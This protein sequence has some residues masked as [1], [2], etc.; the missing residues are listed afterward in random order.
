MNA[1]DLRGEVLTAPTAEMWERMKDASLGWVLRGEDESVLALQEKCA[2]LTGQ[3]AALFVPT[4][5]MGNLI[6]MM[7]MCT[8]GDQVIMESRCHL[9]WVEQRNIAAIAGAAP[10]LLV[11]DKFG[12]MPID[13]VERALTQAE[14]GFLPRTA[15]V[16]I[17]NTH[18]VCGGTCLGPD[19]VRRVADLAHEHG[20][21]AFC[22]G[23]R[24]WNAAVA[25][26]VEPIQLTMHLDA[27]TLSLNK[28][29]GAPYGAILCGRAEIVNRAQYHL[30]SIGGSSVHRAGM[31]AAAALVVVD[32]EKSQLTADHRLARTLAEELSQ[33]DGLSID[34]ETVQTNIVLVELDGE[35]SSGH[36]ATR[37][38]AHGVLASPFGPAT[39]RLVT[40]KEVSSD[41]VE[42]VRRAFEQSL[43]AAS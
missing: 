43:A 17:E 11:G 34:L 3:E 10:R 24:I 4:A 7:A 32:G 15:A 28:G 30:A 26:G 14:Y 6:A 38:A 25:L 23:A 29:L 19:Y 20:A 27:V 18:N 39:I 1:V 12:A 13:T 41:D 5:G 36:V 16:A 21:M 35:S 33:L 37:L 8:P 40:H 2:R 9:F 22:D 42:T 31:F